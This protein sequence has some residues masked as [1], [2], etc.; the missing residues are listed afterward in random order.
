MGRS[1]CW[2]YVT[3]HHRCSSS[4]WA[5]WEPGEVVDLGDVGRFNAERR[6]LHYENLRR[7]YGVSFRVSKPLPVAPRHYRT[8]KYFRVETKLAES[9]G[10][11]NADVRVLAKRK[12]ACIL[13]LSGATE[14]RVTN[15][16]AVM[17]QI[18]ALVRVGGWDLD[19]VAVVGRIQAGRGFAAISQAAGQALELKAI[20]DPGLREILAAEGPGKIL[21]IGAELLL[22]SGWRATG[23]LIYEFGRRETPVFTH[24]IRVKQSLWSRLLP[25]YGQEP[26]LIDPASGRGNLDTLLASLA[27]LP[28]EARRYD[29][30]RSAMRLSELSEIPAEDLFE[31]VTS[32]PARHAV[33]AETPDR[34]DPDH[35]LTWR[36]RKILNA[37]ADSL[38]RRGYPPS[39]REIGEAVGLASTSG[40]FH[41]LDTLRSKGY[42]RWDSGRAR[43]LELRRPDRPAGRPGAGPAEGTGSDVTPR[44]TYVPVV[45]RIAAGAPILAEERIESIVPLPGPLVD[46]GTHFILKV[47]GDSMIS[48]AI[49][50]GDWVVV[51][52]QPVAEDGDIVAAMIDDEATVKTF[53]RSGDHVWL[54]PNSPV[55]TPILGDD[56]VILGKVVAV[57]R[58]V[59]PRPPRPSAGRTGP[60]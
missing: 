42:L 45:G 36:Q 59:R 21:D 58:R 53:K 35:M 25:R 39:R 22:A 4:D 10:A 7:D 23:Y 43:T 9:S 57:L 38:R 54:M 24:T 44:P 41:Q 33:V 2:S 14:T 34:P 40:V 51:R 50:D 15:T 46:E 28:P 16:N 32:L 17:R 26:W 37:I 18:A 19:L 29:P 1:A 6:F 27:H 8:D 56:A 49:A 13:E 47:A 20:G 60:G 5:T 48:A 3:W 12:H 55:H 52:Q 11:L 30:Q 31:E